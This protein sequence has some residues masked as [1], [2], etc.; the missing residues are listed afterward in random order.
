MFEKLKKFLRDRA[1]PK[2]MAQAYDPLFASRDAFVNERLRIES[3]IDFFTD[4]Q[5][6]LRATEGK[7]E[8]QILKERWQALKIDTI[9][10]RYQLTLSKIREVL[11]NTP[12]K[13]QDETHN[14]QYNHFG[15][16][17]DF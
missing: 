1:I 13:P 10:E 16:G 9:L 2:W 7:D 5:K 8:S 11:D 15:G 3:T 4:L 6:E 14:L 12:E 17:D